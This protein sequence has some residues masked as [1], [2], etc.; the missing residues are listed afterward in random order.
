VKLTAAAE[1]P[2]EKEAGVR[3]EKSENEEAPEEAKA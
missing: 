1:S 2:A 3:D